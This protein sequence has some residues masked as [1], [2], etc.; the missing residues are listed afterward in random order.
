[1]IFLNLFFYNSPLMK[2]VILGYID[3]IKIFLNHS[4]VNLADEDEI[5]LLY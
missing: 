2:A 5:L 1:M 4:G 3:I